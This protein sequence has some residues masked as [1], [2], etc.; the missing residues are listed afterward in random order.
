MEDELVR[1]AERARK[2][3]LLAVKQEAAVVADGRAA[4]LSW[5]SLGRLLDCPGESLRRRHAEAGSK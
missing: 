1:A 2:A 3:R 4:G 5:D